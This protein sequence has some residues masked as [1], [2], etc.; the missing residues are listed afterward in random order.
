MGDQTNAIPRGVARTLQAK[1]NAYIKGLVVTQKDVQSL[2]DTEFTSAL[3]NKRTITAA[4]ELCSLCRQVDFSTVEGESDAEK[5]Y[6]LGFIKDIINNQRCSLCRLIA[7]SLRLNWG[8]SPM[9]NKAGELVRCHVF[10]T[11]PNNGHGRR[12]LV[13]TPLIDEEE[14]P[15]GL[16]RLGPRQTLN[17]FVDDLRLVKA[18]TTGSNSV[19]G[20]VVPAQCDITLLRDTFRSCVRSHGI[21][22]EWF[23]F[24]AV[25]DWAQR[26]SIRVE[27]K[28]YARNLRVLDVEEGNI[29]D[30]PIEC[31]YVA[32][33]Y[34]WG[35]S[36]F[37]RLLKE[38]KNNLSSPGALAREVVPRTI[39]DAMRLVKILG[40]RYLWVDALCIIQDDDSDKL[41]QITQMDIIYSSA[42]LTIVAA[43]GV[44]AEA[45]LP[46][47]HVGS[48][49]PAQ[50]VESIR[51]L[52]F[53]AN[54][55][56]LVDVMKQLRWNTRGWTFQEMALSKR[57]L[58]F[59]P[60]QCY[61]LCN[62][63]VLSEDTVLEHPESEGYCQAPVPEFQLSTRAGL[64]QCYRE[65]VERYSTRDFTCENDVNDGVD[66]LL[67]SLSTFEDE[68]FVCGL[69][70]TLLE[71]ALLWLPAGPLRVRDKHRD[72]D[73]FPSWSWTG[74]VGPVI[75]PS[76]LPSSKELHTEITDW[77]IESSGATNALFVDPGYI[78]TGAQVDRGDERGLRRSHDRTFTASPWRKTLKHERGPPTLSA[79]ARDIIDPRR[80]RIQTA[81][82]HFTTQLAT[83]VIYNNPNQHPASTTASAN[84]NIRPCA[85][86]HQT[87][88]RPNRPSVISWVGTVFIETSQAET[89][90]M[91][92]QGEFIVLSS[93]NREMMPTWVTKV[94]LRPEKGLIYS[95]ERFGPLP[96]TDDDD[97]IGSRTKPML[98]N[99]MW[100]KWG[101]EFTSRLGIG[102]IHRDGWALADGL[103]RRIKLR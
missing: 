101:L 103:A 64:W 13:I 48:R 24:L 68:A 53:V 25:P 6:N 92:S 95:E 70:E 98:Y 61:Y 33:S 89:M 57:V 75:Y 78:T 10:I 32:L 30:A 82:L 74:W 58:C 56:E 87:D 50:Y 69:P 63:G 37:L 4:E 77:N 12:E 83:F 67:N 17:L 100:V 51:G 5:D 45:G 31:Q 93:T 47:L 62:R 41:I 55:P 81:F 40:E 44:D 28:S 43:S 35:G 36:K 76:Y 11:G 19:L 23:K 72:G 90:P 91:L 54:G 22:C 26:R 46:G 88:T 85:I 65:I 94:A 8:Y 96:E 34:V 99:V 38:N 73:Q 60:Q 97:E 3:N 15:E 29:I 20:R 14:Y 102:Q 9:W 39:Q 18:E 49:Q 7:A 86:L 79:S 2:V 16:Q 21:Q 71:I 1:A 84:S 42:I 52:R 66:G 59:A 80:S 27:A